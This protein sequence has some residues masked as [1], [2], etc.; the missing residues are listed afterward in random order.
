MP[1]LSYREGSAC[2]ETLRNHALLISELQRTP[3]LQTF[4]SFAN[5]CIFCTDGGMPQRGANFSTEQKRFRTFS[6]MKRKAPRRSPCSDFG[7]SSLLAAP[8]FV[9]FAQSRELLIIF[10]HVRRNPIRILSRKRM[11]Q[12]NF[13][14]AIAKI[15][16]VRLHKHNPAPLIQN[17]IEPHCPRKVEVVERRFLSNT[18]NENLLRQHNIF[19]PRKRVTGSPMFFDAREGV[20]TS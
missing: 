14:I 11:R 10:P 13:P 1:I 16:P 5:F 8:S 4:A 15:L 18:E 17:R 2:K 20:M 6:F 12:K 19:L 3:F 9:L 7:G